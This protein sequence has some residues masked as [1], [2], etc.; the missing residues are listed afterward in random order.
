MDTAREALFRAMM[1][2]LWFTKTSGDVE[3]PTG[4]FGYVINKPEELKELREAFADTIEMYGDPTDE[5]ITGSFYASVDSNGTIRIDR[6]TEF[7]VKQDFDNSE[8]EYIKWSN[9]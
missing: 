9:S 7:G 8:K 5:E 6:G 1:N 4:F 2:D 3:S